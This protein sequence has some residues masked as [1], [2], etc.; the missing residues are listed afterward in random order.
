MLQKDLN[1]RLVGAST[2]RAPARLGQPTSILADWCCPVSLG[3]DT[4][5]SSAC[6]AV[7][8]LVHACVRCCALAQ[9]CRR[10]VLR[11]FYAQQ[12]TPLVLPGA[13]GHPRIR[14]GV[15]FGIGLWVFVRVALFLCC[16]GAP[17][18]AVRPI[19]YWLPAALWDCSRGIGGLCACACTCWV[20]RS[21]CVKILEESCPAACLFRCLGTCRY[22]CSVHSL[23]AM[24][25]TSVL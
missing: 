24:R 5:A 16:R 8:T 7:G 2:G 10:G 17:R 25:A 23:H 13:V 19:T 15:A 6:A 22:C 3:F 18:L 9:T 11:F 1:R 12:L 21:A 20:C 4:G 14:C